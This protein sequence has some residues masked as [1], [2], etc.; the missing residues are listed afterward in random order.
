[1]STKPLASEFDMSQQAIDAFGA[2][3][4]KR[5]P[6]LR[7]PRGTGHHADV[8]AAKSVGLR[9]PVAYSLHYYAHVSHLMAER[10][11]ERWFNGGEISVAF[12]KPVCAGDRVFVKVGERDVQRPP[13]SSE[14][15]LVFQADVFNQLNELVAAGHVSIP[16]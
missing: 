13:E 5:V 3:I 1:M 9:G 4:G 11:G 10:F 8:E 14:D 6:A 2:L 15:R 12:I 16:K 7:R